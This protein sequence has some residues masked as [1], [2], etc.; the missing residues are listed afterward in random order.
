MIKKAEQRL[1]SIP[2]KILGYYT[3]LEKFYQL[4]TN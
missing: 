1:N 4:I 3:L 2:R